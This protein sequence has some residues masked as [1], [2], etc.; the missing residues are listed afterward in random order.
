MLLDR[1]IENLG[2]DVEPFATCGVAAGWR[3]PLRAQDHV[4]L[5]FVLTGSGRLVTGD[6]PDLAL[7]T[8]SLVL[9][10]PGLPHHLE[11]AASPTAPEA[12]SDDTPKA[13]RDAGLSHVHAGPDREAALLVICGA[14]R[15]TWADGRGLFDH[16]SQPVVVT[17]ED[18]PRMRDIFETL[19]AEQASRA[20]GRL[21]MMRALMQQCLVELFRRL[22]GQPECDLPWLNALEDPRL[23]RVLDVIHDDPSRS[24]SLQTLADE[25]AM[26]R[27]AFA[28]RF[29]RVFKQTPMDYVRGV[30]LREAARLLRRPDM[31]VDIA[32]TKAGFASR[33]HFSRAFRQM[34]GKT[35]GAFRA[36]A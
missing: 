10:P 32:A 20:P 21:A 31:S 14:I 23:A 6:G 7:P 19:L 34:F 16:L 22:C 28:S 11:A 8:H 13:W 4:T 25:A 18:Q 5:H 1:V 15:V 33:S 26:S 27:S 9:V 17:F 35:P 30:R 36:G 24:H 12:A 29:R 2:L 3:L